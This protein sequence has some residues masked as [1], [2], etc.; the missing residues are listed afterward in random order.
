[1]SLVPEWNYWERIA[2]YG[3]E[4]N[5]LE[6]GIKTEEQKFI[7]NVNKAF[8]TIKKIFD[9]SD[10]TIEE[11]K[12]NFNNLF[13]DK[14]EVVTSSMNPKVLVYAFVTGCPIVVIDG[15]IRKNEYDEK[16]VKETIEEIRKHYVKDKKEKKK[17]TNDYSR[18]LIE[19]GITPESIIRYYRYFQINLL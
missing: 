13:L 19:N 1:M 18:F 2:L 8:D 4:D 17:E 7:W 12:Q 9:S 15:R 10:E 5:P 14:K 11:L 6:R 16:S 3:L